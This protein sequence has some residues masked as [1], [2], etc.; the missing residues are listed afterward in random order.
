MPANESRGGSYRAYAV[1]A[2]VHVAA[3]MSCATLNAVP[4]FPTFAG[5]KAS[6]RLLLRIARRDNSRFDGL[7]LAELLHLLHQVNPEQLLHLLDR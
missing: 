6:L 5:H 4:R 1:S 2:E 3:G 7:R